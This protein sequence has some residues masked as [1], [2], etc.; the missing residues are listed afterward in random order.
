MSKTATLE[1]IY[2]EVKFVKRR[3]VEIEKHMV[4]VDSIMTAKDH[5][6]LEAYKKEKVSGKLT[7]HK[8]LKQELGL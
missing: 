6:A 2:K 8:K 5:Q 4:D 1:N 3:I 7:S